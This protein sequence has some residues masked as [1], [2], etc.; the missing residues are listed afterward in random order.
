V[1]WCVL[2]VLGNAEEVFG[3]EGVGVGVL[4]GVGF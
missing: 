3:R 2:V 4:L 1:A